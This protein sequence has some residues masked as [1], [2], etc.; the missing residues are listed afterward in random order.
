MLHKTR[1]IILNYI[2]YRETSIIVKVYTEEFGLQTY[3][4]NGIRSPKSKGRIALFQPLN[5]VDLVVYFKPRIE[6]QRIA[7]IKCTHPFFSIPTDIRKMT[8]GIFVGE[9]LVLT[10]KEN[11]GNPLLF[12]YI[13]DALLYLENHEEDIENFHLFFLL[14]LS[15]YLGFGPQSAQDIRM[16][17]AEHGMT[18]SSET[19]Q[20]LQR[21]LDTPFGGPLPISKV[22]RTVALE[23]ILD[24]YRF[25]IDSFTGARS[26]QI[27]KEVLEA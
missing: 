19:I 24:F 27:L 4:E 20:V 5:L 22:Q 17:H 12:S 9:I 11:A 16:S 26:L 18:M 10:L 23:N 6:V 25:N 3:L 8:L 13:Q 7:E 2:R 14:H 15:A 1:G 21:I